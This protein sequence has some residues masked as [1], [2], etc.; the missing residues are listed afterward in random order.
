MYFVGRGGEK[1]K[2]RITNLVD[3]GLR[4]GSGLDNGLDESGYLGHDVNPVDV[5]SQGGI[6]N[7]LD[8]LAVLAGC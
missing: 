2:W 3:V 4:S 8:R 6:N 1:T 5:V 7:S